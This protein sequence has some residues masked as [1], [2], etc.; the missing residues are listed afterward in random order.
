MTAPIYGVHFETQTKS[1]G[2]DCLSRDNGHKSHERSVEHAMNMPRQVNVQSGILESKKINSCR[3]D[4][5]DSHEATAVTDCLLLELI[6][7]QPHYKGFLKQ[8][9]VNVSLNFFLFKEILV[10]IHA[11]ANRAEFNLNE[12]SLQLG[13]S[14]LHI[15]RTTKRLGGFTPFSTK[16]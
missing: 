15:I 16:H 10:Q 13:V 12:L 3:A 5:L 6:D 4:T 9:T 14:K 8:E 11:N 7:N 1:I 2:P